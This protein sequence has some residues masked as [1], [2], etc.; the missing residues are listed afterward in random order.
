MAYVAVP[1]RVLATDV[2]VPVFFGFTWVDWIL[3]VAGVWGLWPRATKLRESGDWCLPGQ[4]H[5]SSTCRVL[6]S[7][8]CRIELRHI[9]TYI[10]ELLEV[11]FRRGLQV[12]EH[13]HSLLQD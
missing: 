13:D 5:G 2:V 10:L 3:R 4:E 9:W 8:H 11:R 6:R 12:L 7:D 1:F